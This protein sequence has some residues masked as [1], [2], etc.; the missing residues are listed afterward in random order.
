MKEKTITIVTLE[1]KNI[2][3]N[4]LEVYEFD[5]ISQRTAD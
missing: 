5:N 3:T 4:C 2:I 1:C